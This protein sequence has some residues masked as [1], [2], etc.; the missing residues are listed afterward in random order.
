M[1][2]ATGAILGLSAIAVASCSDEGDT[3]PDGQAPPAANDTEAPTTDDGDVD[4]SLSVTAADAEADLDDVVL[5]LEFR[6]EQL[7]LDDLSIALASPDAVE[8]SSAA[9]LD[10]ADVAALGAPITAGF[11][12]VLLVEA[13]DSVDGGPNAEHITIR[14]YGGD[15]VLPGEVGDE[16]AAL[17]CRADDEAASAAMAAAEQPE[18]PVVIA[19]AADGSEKFVLDA[20]LGIGLESAEAAQAMTTGSSW[21]VIVELDHDGADTLE[22][23]TEFAAAQSGSP[24]GRL[25][26]VMDGRV[27][28]APTVTMP[29]PGGALTITSADTTEESSEQVAALLR[30]AEAG[31]ELERV[32]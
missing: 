15:V 16:F 2:K 19:C 25:G 10:D 23:F 1:K 22:D 8:L 3:T 20:D 18:D 6:A 26:L 31:V 30:L 7:G 11:R 5:A 17:D 14:G 29:I 13:G 9:D 21:E 27:I 12:P 4:V 32:G 24:Q 28:T